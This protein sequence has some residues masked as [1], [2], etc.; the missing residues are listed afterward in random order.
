MQFHKF[1]TVFF[2]VYTYVHRHGISPLNDEFFVSLQTIPS[3]AMHHTFATLFFVQPIGCCV[4]ASM[5]FIDGSGHMY[6]P[7]RND[8]LQSISTATI[9]YNSF[10][11]IKIIIPNL[12]V[13][14]RNRLYLSLSLFLYLYFFR[15]KNIFFFVYPTVFSKAFS[16]YFDSIFFFYAI[17]DISNVLFGLFLYAI[18]SFI[19]RV[20]P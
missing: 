11:K 2:F 9:S 10:N 1:E 7:I 5:W 18:L 19:H 6:C 15:Q 13:P 3:A 20:F 14:D 16:N 4:F 17:H 12:I 8:V